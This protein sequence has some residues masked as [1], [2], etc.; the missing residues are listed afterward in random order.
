MGFH[1]AHPRLIFHAFAA[2]LVV[3]S[4]SFAYRLQARIT[5]SE[6]R[7]FVTSRSLWWLFRRCPCCGTQT[8]SAP[9]FFTAPLYPDGPGSATPNS[10]GL[11]TSS[12]IVASPSGGLSRAGRSGEVAAVGMR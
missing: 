3:V 2:S 9:R 6:A 7:V 11:G 4:A 12:T 8:W 1:V 10:A 5:L